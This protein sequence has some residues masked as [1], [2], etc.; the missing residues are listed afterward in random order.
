MWWLARWLYCALIAAR[1][2]AGITALATTHEEQRVHLLAS[3]LVRDVLG[4]ELLGAF[5]AVRDADAAWAA[6][7]TPEETVA[8]LRWR[9]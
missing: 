9:Y 5:V 8:S 4:E 3:E 6:E 7:H 1:A 2:A